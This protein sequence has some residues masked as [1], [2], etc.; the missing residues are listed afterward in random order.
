MNREEA[1]S[2]TEELR[3]LIAYHSKKY[4]DEDAPEL[5]DDEFDAG[6]FGSWKRRTPSW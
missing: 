5:E 4:Y 2:R 1:R 3:R 6:S